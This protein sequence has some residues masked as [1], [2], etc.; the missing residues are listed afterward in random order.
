MTRMLAI[1]FVLVC[2]RPAD[3]KCMLAVWNLNLVTVESVSGDGAGLSEEMVR[4]S[5]AQLEYHGVRAVTL[6]Y[7][8]GAATLELVDP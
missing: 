1:G 2:V 4:M 5:A 8:D 6:R 3:A 7:A